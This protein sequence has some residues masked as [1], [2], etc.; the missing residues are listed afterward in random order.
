MANRTTYH[1]PAISLNTR[2]ITITQTLA[3]TVAVIQSIQT[4]YPRPGTFDRSSGR[5][6]EVPDWIAAKA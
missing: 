5:S 3:R 4:A 6:I 2:R 1:G